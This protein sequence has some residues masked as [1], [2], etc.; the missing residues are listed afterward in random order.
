MVEFKVNHLDFARASNLLRHYKNIKMPRE[1]YYYG[2]KEAEKLK[3]I[4]S[5]WIN[6]MAHAGDGRF[7]TLKRII[8][9]PRRS[10]GIPGDDERVYSVHFEFENRIRLD[11][12]NFLAHNG[13]SHLD[14]SQREKS[15]V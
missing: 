6:K 7:D 15:S 5:S 2:L 3:Q 10:N 12:R 8:I 14:H 9:R 11:A 4:F 1:G 13:L